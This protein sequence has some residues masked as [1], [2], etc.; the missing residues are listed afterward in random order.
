MAIYHVH[1][2]VISRST[3]NTVSALAY[4]SGTC[5]ENRVTGEVLNFTKKSVAHVEVLLPKDAPQW[6][7]NIQDLVSKNRTDGV[8]KISDLVENSEKRVDA[9]LYRE[10]EFA[11]PNELTDGQNIALAN[12]FIQD[13]ACGRGMLAIQN[14][15]FDIDND[16]GERR[17]HCHT[18][19]LTR[20]LVEDGL[21]PLKE[22]E[23]N[24]KE[25]H[26]TLREQWA[27]Y[28][29]F[30]L[31]MH[32][33]DV[34]VDHR[35]YEELG[36]GLEPQVKL[37]K[38]VKEIEGK[39][40]IAAD[41]ASY[42][43]EGLAKTWRGKDF[44]DAK[45]RNAYRLL[46]HPEIILKVASQNQ[47]VFK[48]SDV[49]KVID[50]YVTDQALQERL[51]DKVMASPELVVLHQD[52][53]GSDKNDL[54]TT[55]SLVR[56]EISLVDRA[57]R[58]SK[59]VSHGLKI[60]IQTDWKTIQ[61]TN[62]LVLSEDQKNA[63][64]H[65]IADRQLVCIVGYAGAGKTTALKA[66][67]DLWEREGYHVVGMSPTGRAV[68]NLEEVGI[69]SQTRHKFL[70]DF[71]SGRSRFNV[72]T[73][74]IID[75]AGMVD[76]KV[77]DAVLRAVEKLSIKAVILGDGAQLQA[78]EAGDAFRLIT[79]KVA[80][81]ALEDVRRQ[82]VEWQ[83]DATKAFGRLEPK[84]AL[85]QYLEKGHVTFVDEMQNPISEFESLKESRNLRGIVTLYNL[86]HR[87][88]GRM[89][90][91][92]SQRRHEEGRGTQGDHDLLVL[93]NDVKFE[94][95]TYMASNLDA[96]RE[97]MRELRVDPV[98]FA[99]YF[100]SS[101]DH[102][103]MPQ[104]SVLQI[105]QRWKLPL[106]EGGGGTHICDFRASTRE[107]MVSA[108][109]KSMTTYPKETHQMLAYTN[110]DVAALNE[111]AR[112]LMRS[113]GR[114]KGAEY[115]Y[116]TRKEVQDKVEGVT[117]V[118]E[119]R[120]FAIGD[121]LMF[122]KNDRG[123]DVKNGMVGTVEK[124]SKVSITV[125]VGAEIDGEKNASKRLITFS[126]TLY[127]SFDNGWASTIHKSQGMTVDRVFKLASFEEY[128]NLAYVG[129]T[130][131]RRDITVFASRLDFWRD[132]VFLDRLSSV[133]QK[134]SALDYEDQ[135]TLEKTLE[136]VKIGSLKKTIMTMGHHLE[137]MGFVSNALYQKV[138]DGFLSRTI[139]SQED[140]SV[141]KEI[142][143]SPEA[144]RFAQAGRASNINNVEQFTL[145]CLE[146]AKIGSL[147][148]NVFS[149][150]NLNALVCRV[151]YEE[152]RFE[153]TLELAIDRLFPGVRSL[154]PTQ[155]YQA[156]ALAE[157]RCA[158][159]SRLVQSAWEEGRPLDEARVKVT[160]YQA[161]EASLSEEKNFKQQFLDQGYSPDQAFHMANECLR[162]KD[163]YGVVPSGAYIQE[164]GRV[165]ESIKDRQNVLEKEQQENKVPLFQ[166]EKMR[167]AYV[168]YAVE[169]EA[170]ESL[171]ALSHKGESLRNEDLRVIHQKSLN[172][173]ALFDRFLTLY[174]KEIDM[175]HKLQRGLEQER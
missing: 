13:Q 49:Q 155:T 17:P 7:K 85:S 5:I 56:Q 133:R 149:E 128:R 79:G 35:S 125:S 72:N 36:V 33:F 145:R 47:T 81:V 22:R 86:S 170:K 119:S 111:K 168:Q 69:S 161:I 99:Q 142:V 104:E 139:K 105:I 77:F 71:E 126:P 158:L 140:L 25:F 15:H 116:I 96:C 82:Q 103:S 42:E 18:L 152:K 156:M 28:Q 118:E 143:T 110:E 55:A 43:G 54:M 66:A 157:R 144:L 88:R 84:V 31:K 53:N 11:L 89:L 95:A 73:V 3:H 44:I 64:L 30:H 147:S 167:Q 148:E 14:F 121:Q 80:A 76:V 62:S 122:L 131:H 27:H 32:G 114:V 29:N 78:V 164:I 2:K 169:V 106:L 112:M 10:F 146:D 134:T 4:R 51:F 6:A 175:E 100:A 57:V 46:S 124:L 171:R 52:I 59:T 141:P 101:F 120:R 132:E 113:S 23:W 165:L 160:G 41:G 1:H 20:L 38:N 75:E 91:E 65:M 115:T 129:M 61:E 90:Y 163:V 130:R 97:L 92:I 137:A 26:A 153:K 123:L 87:M 162:L 136:E 68:Q 117:I 19:L 60:S 94:C 93:W 58:L 127:A 40:I 8:Q 172:D 154:S 83:R 135:E 150:K 108:W 16:T 159:E 166:D 21:S 70:L 24:G 9:Q 109:A 39:L 102:K 174:Q 34:R 74:L 63:V 67:K 151:Q 48:R 173:P 107:A 50:R 37:G 138:A 12:E 45:L 98:P